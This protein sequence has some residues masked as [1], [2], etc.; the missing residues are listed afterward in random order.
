M[1]QAGSLREWTS[2]V[3]TSSPSPDSIKMIAIRKVWKVENCRKATTSHFC[4]CVSIG[5]HP[6]AFR[7][8]PTT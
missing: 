2:L 8:G 4:E 1:T 7:E 6:K 3:S 5:H